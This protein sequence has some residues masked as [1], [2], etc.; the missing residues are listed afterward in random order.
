[1]TT[2]IIRE[3]C[4]CSTIHTNILSYPNYDFEDHTDYIIH[5]DKITR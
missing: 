4:N 2:K 1:M 5:V 3:C